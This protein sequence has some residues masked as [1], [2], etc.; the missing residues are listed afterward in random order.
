MIT[1]TMMSSRMY[2][3]MLASSSDLM[4]R[5]SRKRLRELLRAG[6]VFGQ[7]RVLPHLVDDEDDDG[8]GADEEDDKREALDEDDVGGRQL[9]DG[10]ERDIEQQRGAHGLP[11]L[12]LGEQDRVG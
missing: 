8:S 10:D 11:L 6:L 2:R 4:R 12:R 1:T 3:W 5:T 9:G 7:L